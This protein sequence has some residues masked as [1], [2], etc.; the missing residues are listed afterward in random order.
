MTLLFW[1]VRGMNKRSRRRDIK[2]HISKFHPTVIGLIETKVRSHK[3]YRITDCIPNTW[4]YC[5]NYA[6]SPRGRIWVTW[7]EAIWAGT[8]L[9]V[10]LQHITIQLNNK[11]GLSFIISVIYGENTEKDRKCLWED[12][13]KIHDAHHNLPWILIGDFNTCRYA[14]EKLGGK[15]LSASKLQDFNDCL[16][17]CGLTDVKSI[18][19]SWSWHNN[20][21]G[22]NRIFGKLD[23]AICNSQ[24]IN[25]LPS[26]YVE[27]KCT[28]SSDHTP[29]LLHLLQMENSGPKPFKFYNHWVTCQGFFET[30]QQV[31]NG[32][33]EGSHMF[34]LV[35]K[36]KA[37]K[38]ALKA[39]A[40][41][42]T[43]STK[44]NINKIS[45][46]LAIIQNNIQID[47]LNESLHTQEN[48]L[49]LQLED[50]LGKEEEELRQRSRQLWLQKGDRNSK[51]FYNAIKARMSRNNLRHLVQDDGTSISNMEGIKKEAPTFYKNLYHQEDYWTVFPKV[52]TKRIL[53]ED[54]KSWLVREVS[55]NEVKKAIFQLN[56]EKA[57]GPD[58][59]N[60]HFFQSNWELVKED[61][62]QAV[63]SFFRSGRLLKQINHTFLTLI[64]KTHEATSL[65]DYRPISCCNVIYKIISKVMS[66]RLKVVI[67]ELISSNQHAFLEGRQIGECS[68]LA[69]ELI[70][71]FNKSHGK[72]ACIKVDLQKAFDCI[73]REFVYYIMHRMNFPMQWISWIKECLSTPS[74]SVLINGSS[75]G[76]FDSNRGIRQGDPLSP[77][78]FVLVME[79]WSI[80][81]ELACDSG[82][83]QNFKRNRDLQVSHLLFADDMLVFCRANNTS[84]QGVNE[85]LTS[86]SF[87][88]GLSINKVKSKA[89]FSKGCRNKGELC[90]LLGISRG[91]FHV[92]YLGLPLSI[93]YPK[94][95]HFLPLLDKLRSKV[96]GWMVHSLS[97]AGRMEL[98][99]SVL[100]NILSYWYLSYDFP[101]SV[102]KEVERIFANFLWKGRMH[103]LSWG[104]ICKPKSE[105]GLGI[106]RVKDLCDAAGLKKIWRLLN[107]DTLWSVWFRNRYI[108]TDNF[109]EVKPHILDSGTWKQ[110]LVLKSHAMECMRKQIGNGK[111][112]S[113]W[114][115]P[116]IE[117]GRLS[118][119][120]PHGMSHMS[121]TYDWK[122]DRLI[123]DNQWSLVIPSLNSLWS[124]ISKLNISAHED[125]WR[126]S[127]SSNGLFSFSSA[128]DSIRSSSAAFPYHNVVWFPSN[129]P[130]MAC[131]LL[132]G[133]LDRLPTRSRL[134]NFSI[135]ESDLCV[136]CDGGQETISHLFF[137]CPFSKYLWTLCK[138]KLR[139]QNT[140]VGHLIQEATEIKN[141]FKSKD[142]TY[143]VARLAFNATV[144]HIW[145]ER[146]RRI[147]QRNKMH[148]VMIFRS[149]YEDINLLLRTCTWKVNN[150]EEMLSNWGL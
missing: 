47:P 7:N 118:D 90:S 35:T 44:G 5:N 106:R 75:N 89:F 27:Y 143:K 119:L 144:W 4:S 33:Y 25:T 43:T 55:F 10:S 146:N 31:W 65:S 130:K 28:S 115:D 72:R 12:I 60:A 11:G 52:V 135:I 123:I 19:Y 147:F 48:D 38:T 77:Y 100:L 86:L 129:S 45:E 30:V 99:K 61:V 71:D 112:T 57:P 18:G 14:N 94:A 49:K 122:V 13:N 145:Q 142:K 111:T 128:W 15:L 114:F 56:P 53:T 132:K 138:M 127:P 98:L 8:V 131:C 97:F 83:I 116:W 1:N 21:L 103:T 104:E 3:S 85:L 67:K 79:Y 120:L 117:E 102:V 91:K 46:E 105:G 62:V 148:K 107:F 69:H 51:F 64:P 54:A 101:V 70:R 82:K 110:I 93:Q 133:L 95:R 134:K 42:G 29:M 32:Y 6:Y 66:N 24:W 26:A 149:I 121:Y 109:W 87:H 150:R 108:K 76:F 63:L 136:L 58:G 73:N 126:W 139:M 92:R 84:F 80:A 37:L 22:S 34:R 23:R 124:S 81:M 125:Y 50:W 68:M 36:L 88:T 2:N 41:T 39:W 78:I 40:A 59:Y 96:D 141:I 20:Q 113:I 74:F 9:H 137:E 140:S 17:K 16:H